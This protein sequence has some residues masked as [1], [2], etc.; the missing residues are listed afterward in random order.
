MAGGEGLPYGVA[1]RG[2]STAW[3]LKRRFQ[4]S[5]EEEK[6][7]K[8]F[9]L[10]ND[11]ADRVFS[12]L[13]P[14]SAF[15]RSQASARA[16]MPVVLSYRLRVSVHHHALSGVVARWRMRKQGPATCVLDDKSL[17]LVERISV[18]WLGEFEK[19]LVEVASYRNFIDRDVSA[20]FVRLELKYRDLLICR[21]RAHQLLMCKLEEE[22]IETAVIALN[23]E[24]CSIELHDSTQT[25][26]ITSLEQALNVFHVRRKHKASPLLLKANKNAGSSIS[27]KGA[28]CVGSYNIESVAEEL[29]RAISERQDEHIQVLLKAM[30]GSMVLLDKA[31]QVLDDRM[32]AILSHVLID[33]ETER[34][35]HT[36]T[37]AVLKALFDLEPD[38]INLFGPKLIAKLEL[39]ADNGTNLQRAM[40]NMDSLLQHSLPSRKFF[41]KNDQ[42]QSLICR[43]H[44]RFSPVKELKADYLDEWNDTDSRAENEGI[45]EVG[46]EASALT[47]FV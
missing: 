5:C 46:D 24:A 17:N 25:H 41:L 33:Y 37:V 43:L 20:I 22:E 44:H 27:M 15:L 3:R 38:L 45:L 1:E 34:D 35:L 28:D 4:R 7:R 30:R 36:D 11:D 47:P 6:G 29:S 9:L 42:F 31:G 21:C 14:G 12:L 40:A 2:W 19:F 18:R 8:I 13:P 32:Q 39:A 10:R 23:L 26:I 16:G